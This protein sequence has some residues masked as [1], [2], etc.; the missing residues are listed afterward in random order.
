MDNKT[1]HGG[2]LCGAVRY[3]VRGEPARITF[4][5]CK[6][7]QRVTGAAYLVK[8]NYPKENVELTKGRPAVH[9]HASTRSGNSLTTHFCSACGTTVFMNAERGASMCGVLAGT[10][11]N[12]NAFDRN[13]DSR[14]LFLD[15]A[16]IGTVIPAGVPVYR[17]HADEL[18]GT[19]TT[20]T[21]YE[22]PYVVGEAKDG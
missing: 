2:C 22:R 8:P 20:P 21:I 5:H 9:E 12:P 6:Y 13:I 11:D 14:I 1:L 17:E 16:Q 19:P 4:C 18:D 3:E 7:C 15:S 10:L